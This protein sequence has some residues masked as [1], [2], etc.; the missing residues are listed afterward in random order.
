LPLIGVT[1]GAV[2]F[3][4]ARVADRSVLGALSYA[5]YGVIPWLIWAAMISFMRHRAGE[6]HPPVGEV[7]LSPWRRRA[8]IAML[9]LFVSIATPVPFRP[10]L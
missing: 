8:A 7:P 1:V 3:A 5:K 9:I 10:V 6:Y 4:M 2:M